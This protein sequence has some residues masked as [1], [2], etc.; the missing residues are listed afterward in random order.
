MNSNKELIET[1]DQSLSY[2]E[3]EKAFSETT[4][5]P[6]T[7][8][9]AEVWQLVQ[10]GKDRQN[11][12]CRLMELTNKACANCLSMQQELCNSAFEETKTETCNFG[13]CETAVPVKQGDRLIGFL[14]TGQVF[15]DEP[16]EEGFEQALDQ[17]KKWGIK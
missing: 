16:T 12:F 8:R 1:L 11:G 5:L 15:L 13:I 7:L 14:Q 4:G 17:L 10:Q 6:L 3:F 9:P 2:Q